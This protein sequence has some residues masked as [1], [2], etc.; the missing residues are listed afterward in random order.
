MISKDL[1]LKIDAFI[2]ENKENIL[3]DIATLIEIPS[4]SVD[5]PAEA[6]FG[7][8]CKKALDAA[9]AICEGMD[10]AT[11]TYDYYAIDGTL[12]YKYTGGI[13]P[14]IPEG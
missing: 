5:G 8:G 3:K 4:V 6:P 9:L 14:Y 11:K 2:A 13:D 1:E 10:M 7:E 12:L